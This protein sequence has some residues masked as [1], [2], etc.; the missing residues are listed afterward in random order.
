[1]VVEALLAAGAAVDL[2][3]KEGAF[4]VLSVIIQCG[5]VSFMHRCAPSRS[6]V[7]AFVL[8]HTDEYIHYYCCS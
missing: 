2:Q 4:G 3:D 6:L 1:V 7:S 5:C 8:T